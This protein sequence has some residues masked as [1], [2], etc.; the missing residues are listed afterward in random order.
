MKLRIRSLS[1]GTT[2]GFKDK[3]KPELTLVLCNLLARA[4]KI[5]ANREDKDLRPTIQDASVKLAT[6][7][8][9]R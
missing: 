7:W 6:F 2:E 8:M 4:L 3:F 1:H 9:R 5:D